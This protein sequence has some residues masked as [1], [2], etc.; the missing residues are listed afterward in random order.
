MV[1]ESR[2]EDAAAAMRR[3]SRA[4][5]DGRVE[6]L[7][8]IVHPEI[9]MVFP[10]FTGRVQGREDF[11]AGFR[12]LSTRRNRPRIDM[13]RHVNRDINPGALEALG[14]ALSAEAVSS[15]SKSAAYSPKHC[16]LMTVL[17]ILWRF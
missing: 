5:L 11:L 12:D 3:I 10:G 1:D 9:V 16:C 2:R 13:A 6:D 4:W 17:L 14:H 8:P 15:F 7:A